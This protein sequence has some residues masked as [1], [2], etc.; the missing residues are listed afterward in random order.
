[1]KIYKFKTTEWSLLM[2][3]LLI[4]VLHTCRILWILPELPATIPIHFGF[5]GDPDSYGSSSMIW[6]LPVLGFVLHLV[7]WLVGSRPHIHNIPWKL[8][9]ENEESLLRHSMRF[10]L[11]MNLMI[12]VTFY[13]STLFTISLVQGSTHKLSLWF[14]PAIFIVL[15]ILIVSF[16]LTGR[17]L[18]QRHTRV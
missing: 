17:R 13:L 12:Q 3:A 10:A 18:S 15:G 8:T 2:I 5:S 14:L 16:F 11:T 1:M 7:F 6:L 4:L 9:P